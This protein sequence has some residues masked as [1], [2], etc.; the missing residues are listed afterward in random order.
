MPSMS[1]MEA[2]FELEHTSFCAKTSA[3][4]NLLTP[5]MKADLLKGPIVQIYRV[6]VSRAV[7][8]FCF[9]TLCI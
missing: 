8:G 9:V 2:L 3:L 5:H 6:E 7:L 4:I 1:E